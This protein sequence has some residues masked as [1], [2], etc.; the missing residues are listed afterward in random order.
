MAAR[1][2]NRATESSAETAPWPTLKA[3]GDLN[4]DLYPARASEPP[5]E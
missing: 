2:I 5:T 3:L 4:I 1:A